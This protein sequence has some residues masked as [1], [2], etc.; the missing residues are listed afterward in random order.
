MGI[1]V[2][3]QQMTI[4]IIIL[5]I[6]QRP[7][8]IR[9][10]STKEFITYF[11]SG[12]TTSFPWHWLCAVEDITTEDGVVCSLKLPQADWLP[13]C[14]TNHGNSSNTIA[15]FSSKRHGDK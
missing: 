13:R 10:L 3:V 9:G 11:V 14:L 2:V 7:R 15:E 12:G 8:D 5:L 4:V 6:H 1:I